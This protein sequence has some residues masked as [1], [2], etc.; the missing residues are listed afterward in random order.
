[1]SAD[2]GQLEVEE[3]EK[4]M[5]TARI[6]ESMKDAEAE[7]GAQAEEEECPLLPP[8]TEGQSVLVGLH[9]QGCR[10]SC[11]CLDRHI[12]DAALAP[13]TPT[14]PTGQGSDKGRRCVSI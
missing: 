2:L 6:E 7:S 5:E 4:E 13:P 8:D 14:P 3:V 1:M 12:P 9:V 10:S 11:M